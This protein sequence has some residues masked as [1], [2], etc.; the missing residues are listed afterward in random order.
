MIAMIGHTVY[1]SDRTL[2][3]CDAPCEDAATT[4]T[5][6]AGERI[7]RSRVLALLAGCDALCV[8]SPEPDAVFGEFAG[9]FVRVEA[10]GGA[11]TD[12]EGR[13]AMILRNGRW[14][15]PKGH[16][17]CGETPAEC[18][19]R[20]VAE[21]TGIVAEPASEPLCSTLHCYDIYGKWEMKRTVWF[22]MRYASGE[23]V[24]Q[25]S[26]GIERV[27]WLG[28]EELKKAVRASYPTIRQVFCRL[29]S[30]CND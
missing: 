18:A 7:S 26:E 11:V 23:A 3:F 20:E 24:P 29:E 21:E 4:V 10:A 30:V 5:L 1:F 16:V 28:G 13:V 2:R 6:A 17:E 14:D 9:E 27:E 19:V 8:V 25:R 15:L 12:A 22:A